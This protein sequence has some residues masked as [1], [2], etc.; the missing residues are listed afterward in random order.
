MPAAWPIV[1]LG[2]EGLV[3][4][5]LVPIFS[6]Y[7]GRV[8]PI[9]G[10][11][12]MPARPFAYLGG[13]V[14]GLS[15]WP[16]V[17]QLL[18]LMASERLEQLKSLVGSQLQKFDQEQVL[19]IGVLVLQA[20]LEELFFRGYLF[21]ALRRHLA[22]AGT[23]GVSALLFGLV[24]VVFG[25]ALGWERFI[26]STALGLILGWVRCTSGS[27]WPG[28]LLHASHNA[29]LQSLP[30]LTELPRTWMVVGAAGCGVGMG[31]VFLGAKASSIKPGR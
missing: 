16:L 29:V 30:P 9:S 18:L 17:L 23:I 10:F 4:F 11:G 8:S 26:P 25:G 15:L 5:G 6:A 1:A 14:L 12:L 28:M 2:L 22:A 7:M 21:G 24:H 13:F 31:L 19:V 27:V 3:L 20:I